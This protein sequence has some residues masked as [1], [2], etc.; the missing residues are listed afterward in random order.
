MDISAHWRVKV[1]S[2]ELKR[3]ARQATYM[4]PTNSVQ[5]PL[6]QIGMSPAPIAEQTT[7]YSGAKVQMDNL[8]Y[9]IHAVSSTSSM[10]RIDHQKRGK[11]SIAETELARNDSV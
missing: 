6:L 4:S 1:E 5:V 7:L 10:G 3:L 9:V 11:R 8:P 2:S